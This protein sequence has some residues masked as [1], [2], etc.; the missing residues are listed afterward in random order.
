[1]RKNK[2]LIVVD[3]QNDFID[4]VLGTEEAVQKVPRIVEKIKRFDGVVCA[5]QDTH[6]DK[7]AA[8]N[9]GKHLPVPHC[10]IGTD[11]H[12][13]Q[14]DVLAAIQGKEHMTVMK[15]SF[16]STVLWHKI[17]NDMVDKNLEL[18]GVG[19]TFELIGFC[20]DICVVS[21]VLILKA[22]FP[23]ANIVVDASCCAGTTPENH[24]KALDVMRCC[25]IDIV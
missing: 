22:Y 24:A 14:K 18:H 1:M 2:Y 12:K 6:T 7:Y 3:V 8:S 9:E 20:T 13:I 10:I 25:Q 11:G 19:T 4:G 15:D 16:G 23:E 21:N 5:T 17:M